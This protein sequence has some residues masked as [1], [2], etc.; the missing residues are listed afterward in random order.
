[1]EGLIVRLKE[2]MTALSTSGFMPL[3]AKTLFEMKT[4]L[5]KAGFTD[6]Q[7]MQIVIAHGLSVNKS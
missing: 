4:E 7:A 1:M 3:I 6:E 2:M 5:V